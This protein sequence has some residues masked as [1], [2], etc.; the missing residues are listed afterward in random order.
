MVVE[1]FPR[2]GADALARGDQEPI[3]INLDIEPAVFAPEWE[4]A[5]ADTGRV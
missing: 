2:P 4:R 3:V 1:S 5:F